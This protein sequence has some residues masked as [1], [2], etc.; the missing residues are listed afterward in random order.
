MIG[1]GKLTSKAAKSAG[2]ATGKL[3]VKSAKH[4]ARAT[5]TGV[6]LSYR[7]SKLTYR[8]LDKAH[9]VTACRK[10]G[11]DSEGTKAELVARMEEWSALW[12]E[13]D[14]E[15]VVDEEEEA[16]IV[17]ELEEKDLAMRHLEN[18]KKEFATMKAPQLRAE[19]TRRNLDESGKKAV[20]ME[21]LA[22][23]ID[24]EA[25]TLELNLAAAALEA[26]EA[27]A[28]AKQA[29]ADAA[30]AARQFTPREGWLDA[31]FEKTLDVTINPLHSTRHWCVL[32]PDAFVWFAQRPEKGKGG[33][34]AKSPKQT[35][36]LSSLTPLEETDGFGKVTHPR[37]QKYT[38]KDDSS[39]RVLVLESETPEDMVE[40]VSSLDNSFAMI[41]TAQRAR[42]AEK[43][44]KRA[45][46][47]ETYSWRTAVGD[48][49]DACKAEGVLHVHH[50]SMLRGPRWVVI[51]TRWL[52]FYDNAKEGDHIQDRVAIARLPM[53]A[54]VV[55]PGSVRSK[56][57]LTIDVLDSF[58]L[59]GLSSGTIEFEAESQERRHAW[60]AAL[61]NSTH[62]CRGLEISFGVLHDIYDA[63]CN[64]DGELLSLEGL[65][66]LTA[67]VDAK[68]IDVEL[69]S[70]MKEIGACDGQDEK[71]DTEA[72]RAEHTGGKGRKGR[73]TKD[74]K[75]K[76]VRSVTWENF[77][78][79]YFAPPVRG[80]ATSQHSAK[81]KA[82]LKLAV[83]E[84]VRVTQV[85]ATE[86]FRRVDSDHDGFLDKHEFASLAHEMEL[87]WP[88]ADIENAFNEIDSDS[89]GQIGFRG[90]HA[91]LLTKSPTPSALLF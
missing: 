59:E 56:E 54:C 40:W 73:K 31:R 28:I 7:G 34:L 63:H 72:P 57:T 16:A 11:L 12:N 50:Q 53:E 83:R 62:G 42:Q 71:G 86:C 90:T 89:S 70:L 69:E 46:E 18:A 33:K 64:D 32:Q 17:K 24:T 61:Q 38:W 82:R 81:L 65:G 47:E 22:R 76:T 58:W 84:Q 66:H 44:A 20:L 5:V 6:K 74:A 77:S 3:A 26:K 35:I 13:E 36:P 68:L 75:K 45:K 41:K 1:G 80:T 15:V 19:L 87:Y 85:D 21:R 52:T 55:R 8:H 88:A 14:D 79:W 37:I 29:A 9:L 49:S 4:G 30:E 25:K 48:S 91:Q 39:E 51:S 10:R 60:V 67:E 78:R 43:K 23:A 27:R 2:K